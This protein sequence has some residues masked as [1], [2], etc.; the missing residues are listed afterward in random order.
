LGARIAEIAGL[1]NPRHGRLAIAILEQQQPVIR[2]TLRMPGGGG[3]AVPDPGLREI[4]RDAAPELV[5]LGE[6]ERGIRIACPRE[7]PPERHGT[8]IFTDLPGVDA[9]L[10]CRRGAGCRRRQH[11]RRHDQ[12]HHTLPFREA[13]AWHETR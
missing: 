12:R 3:F 6:I 10:H 9:I 8:G 4:G 5:G 11:H 1:L 13:L 2:G 7:R